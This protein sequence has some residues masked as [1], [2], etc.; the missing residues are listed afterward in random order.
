MR[1]HKTTAIAQQAKSDLKRSTLQYNIQF[2][3]P[4]RHSS[5]EEYVF[6]TELNDFEFGNASFFYNSH[7]HTMHSYRPSIPHD[8]PSLLQH[9]MDKEHDA[10]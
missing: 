5:N 10:Q 4:K 2:Y 1:V 8:N 9:T 6:P 3:L 7:I